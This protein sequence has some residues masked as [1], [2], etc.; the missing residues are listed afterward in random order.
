[1]PHRRSHHRTR[2]PT[3]AASFSKPPRAFLWGNVASRVSVVRN[4]L[5]AIHDKRPREHQDLPKRLR[6]DASVID[7]PAVSYCISYIVS[8]VVREGMPDG[9]I[10]GVRF[11]TRPIGQTSIQHHGHIHRKVGNLA[12]RLH[13]ALMQHDRTLNAKIVNLKRFGERLCRRY[14]LPDLTSS[15][16]AR[17]SELSNAKSSSPSFLER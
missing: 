12:I 5:R 1:M 10:Q 14:D 8:N 4:A 17:W 6:Q 2:P 3:R 7:S 13:I 9:Q 15:G 16:T 11:K